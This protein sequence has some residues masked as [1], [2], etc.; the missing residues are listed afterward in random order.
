MLSV[1]SGVLSSAEGTALIG[2]V[3][4]MVEAVTRIASGAEGKKEDYSNVMAV[5]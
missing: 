5:L 1:E 4:D 3:D 2:P